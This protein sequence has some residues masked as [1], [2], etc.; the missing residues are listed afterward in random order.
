M[1]VYDFDKTIFYPDSMML[2][3]VFCIKRHPKL[4]FTYVPR[5]CK[6]T[7][8]YVFG[9]IKTDRLHAKAN[10]I[11]KYLDNPDIDITEY[12]EEYEKNISSWYIKQKRED[13]LIISA[14]PE[15]LL[16]PIANKLNVNLIG[17]IVDKESGA[18]IGNVRVAKEKAKYFIEKDMPLIENFYSDS[19]SDMP[20]ALLSE[21]AFLV[22]DKATNP[23]PW[24]HL[25]E[26]L[27]KKVIKKIS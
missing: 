2:F 10:S 14:S 23:I 15:Y 25:T 5:L 17:T 11:I 24:P 12:W 9:R 27:Y 13:D 19:L 26:E 4:L 21:K 20:I 3:T 7:I 18:M 8:L 16:R 22:I 6:C 1:N